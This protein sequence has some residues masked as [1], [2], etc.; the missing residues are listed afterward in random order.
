MNNKILPYCA[1]PPPPS[2][3]FEKFLEWPCCDKYTSFGHW[4]GAFGLQELWKWT[5]MHSE[6]IYLLFHNLYRLVDCDIA[7]WENIFPFLG[8]STKH[9]NWLLLNL[10]R[11]WKSHERKSVL[12]NIVAN[13]WVGIV[14]VADEWSIKMEPSWNDSAREI[15]KY[16][17][18]CP[19]HWHFVHHNWHALARNRTQGSVLGG[20]QL[21]ARAMTWA[22]NTWIRV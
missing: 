17:E 9:V 21:T 2:T 13:C 3:L 20:Q 19:C 5:D 4:M 8:N 14:L 6:C 7:G 1:T 22:R 10:P 16:R 15:P 18:K 12:F 11:R